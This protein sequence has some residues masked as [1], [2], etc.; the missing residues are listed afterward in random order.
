MRSSSPPPS[1]VGAAAAAAASNL[2]DTLIDK[3]QVM[4]SFA[5]IDWGSYGRTTLSAD[6]VGDLGSS[7]RQGVGA[8]HRG[9]TRLTDWTRVSTHHPP[10][11]L[12]VKMLKSC[13]EKPLDF[14]L[15]DAGDAK[16]LVA[17]LVK[18]LKSVSDQTVQQY[19]LTHVEEILQLENLPQVIICLSILQLVRFGAIPR[20]VSHVP[21]AYLLVTMESVH[22]PR[23]HA[24][25]GRRSS[26]RTARPSTPRPSCGPSRRAT[27]TARRRPPPSW[28][29]SSRCVWTAWTMR[30]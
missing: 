19:A 18:L 1:G 14:L 7:Y 9:P 25:S 17:T 24:H 21:P 5:G 28:R 22:P 4:A 30:T 8:R 23:T 27:S 26:R 29:S 20:T 11:T 15:A 16:L 12:Q 13:D 6:E 10:P 2:E 3:E